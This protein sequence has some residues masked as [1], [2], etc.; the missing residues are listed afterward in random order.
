MGAETPEAKLMGEG[1][2]V[3]WEV[4]ERGWEKG[5]KA[6]GAEACLTARGCRE[7]ADDRGLGAKLIER[8]TDGQGGERRWPLRLA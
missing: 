3:D 1:S 5:R 7:R 4:R 8:R 6:W 2:V